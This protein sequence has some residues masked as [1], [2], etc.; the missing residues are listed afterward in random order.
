[1]LSLRSCS[2]DVTGIVQAIWRRML[3]F[4]KG[5]A[6][7]SLIAA[8]GEAGLNCLSTSPSRKFHFEKLRGREPVIIS[9][10]VNSRIEVDIS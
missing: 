4:G 9:V 1:M 8:A 7:Q 5:A 3:I 10:S 2:H 6:S